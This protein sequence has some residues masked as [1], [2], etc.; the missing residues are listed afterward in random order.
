MIDITQAPLHFAT[1]DIQ[2]CCVPLRFN[3][4]ERTTQCASFHEPTL[5][6]TCMINIQHDRSS[7]T[8]I[9]LRLHQY[10]QLHIIYEQL[11]NL[12]TYVIPYC[13]GFSTNS[14]LDVPMF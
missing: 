7:Y 11:P 9:T 6:R 13:T 8:H 14:S 5:A 12:C 4:P 2:G 3:I 10:P 1:V